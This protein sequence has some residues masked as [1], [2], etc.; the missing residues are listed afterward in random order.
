M[1]NNAATKGTDLAAFFEPTESYGLDTWREVMAVNIDAMFLVAREIGGR[2]ANRQRGSII[3]ASSIYGVV[4][5][6]QRIYESSQ[7][8][9]RPIN[10]PPAYSASKAAVIGLTRHLATDWGP[11]TCG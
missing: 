11:F 4:A 6:D 5:P 3:Q 8:L 7:Y 9:D 10:T 1:H 2:M